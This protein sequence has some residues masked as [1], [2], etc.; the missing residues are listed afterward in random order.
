MTHPLDALIIGT[1]FGG[2]GMAVYLQQAGIDNYLV[3]EKADDVGG[4]WRDNQYPGAACDV[5]SHLYSFSFAPN[6]QWSRK[7]A[8]QDEIRG[9]IRRC[10]DQ[11][12][13][14]PRLRLGREVAEARF[15]EVAGTWTVTTTGGETYVTR[16]LITATGQLN[17]PAFPS[18]PGIDSFQGEVFHSA[19]WRH[20]IDLRGKRVAVVGTGASAIQFVPEIV[21]QV[22]SLVLFQRSAPH[23]I[24]KPDRPYTTVEKLAFEKAPALMAGSRQWQYLSHEYRA[25]AFT[26][27]QQFMALPEWQ[28]KRHL[29]SQVKDPVLRDKLTPKDPIG[30]KRILLSN[31]YYSALAQPHVQVVNGAVQAV[32]A[33]GITGADGVRHEVDVIIYGTGFKATEFLAP[34]RVVNGQGTDLNTA[35]RDGAEAYLGITVSGFPN[36][37]MLYGPN[38][39]LGHSSIIFMLESQMNYI[40]QCVGRLVDDR[41]RAL[42]VLPT[43]QSQFNTALQQRL[44][45]SV[46]STGCDSWY[47]NDKGRNTANWPGFTFE[48]RYRTRRPDWADYRVVAGASA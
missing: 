31:N 1:G 47:V 18:V 12:G 4:V 27:Y 11:F 32:D 30:C 6:T 13:V 16:A 45:Q 21:P 24:P 8:M 36:L 40:R 9:Y 10:T 48:Y 22:K 14:T 43:A 46:W 7:F 29:A 17:R 26:S 19:R 34:M 5:P 25:L 2:I 28:F 37:F 44:S 42:D 23:V 3:L 33:G 35:W 39:N 20:D 15:D 38:T 41:L